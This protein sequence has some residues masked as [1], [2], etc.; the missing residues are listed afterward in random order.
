MRITKMENIDKD[1]I[2]MELVDTQGDIAIA[3]INLKNL[4]LQVYKKLAV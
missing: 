1:N 4:M 3:N 2:K